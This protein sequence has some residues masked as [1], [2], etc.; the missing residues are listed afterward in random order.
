MTKQ[1]LPFEN[2]LQLRSVVQQ[3]ALTLAAA[4]VALEFE[5]RA[6]TMHHVLVK[7]AEERVD[8]FRL[9]SSSVYVNLHGIRASIVDFA[10]S[11]MCADIGMHTP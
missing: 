7:E 8:Q 2:A 4:E 9:L 10:A 11:R 1:D 3:V 6:L 5:H